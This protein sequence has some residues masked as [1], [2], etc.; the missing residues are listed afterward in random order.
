[1]ARPGRFQPPDFGQPR[2]DLLGSHHPFPVG[3]VAVGDP[4]GDGRTERLAAADAAAHLGRVPLD[5][6]PPPP[7]IAVLPPREVA[8]EQLEIHPQ[9]G[10]K[11][12]EDGGEP[13]AV[14]LPGGGQTQPAHGNRGYQGNNGHMRY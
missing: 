1:M 6:H 8:G 10:G 4:E 13:G 9:P 5:L 14:A 11:P 12:G 3:V 7:S 2:V